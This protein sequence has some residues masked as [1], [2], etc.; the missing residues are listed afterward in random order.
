MSLRRSVRSFARK[1]LTVKNIG[2]P[3]VVLV[4]WGSYGYRGGP[5]LGDLLA[6]DNLSAR[7]AAENIEHAVVSHPEFGFAGHFPVEDIYKIAPARKVVFVCGPL[8]DNRDLRDFLAIHRKARKIAV[9]VSV[10]ENHDRMNRRF[11][12]IVGRD[13]VERSTFDLAI[14][15]ITPPPATFTKKP[16]TIGIC[17]RGKQ[18]EYGKARVAL[19]DKASSI[20]DGLAA[21]S[22]LRPVVI[23]TV[24]TRDNPAEAIAA[25]FHAVDIVL[26]TRMHGALLSL[27][28]GKP[29]IAIDQIPGGAKVSA[30]VGKTGWP[31]VYRAEEVSENMLAGVLKELLM[32]AARDR[33]I[34]A[35][36]AIEKLTE[37]ALTTS[38]GAIALT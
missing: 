21:D 7:L 28:A 13:G 15:E 12:C 11:D 31:F 4:W 35:Q 19:S 18:T 9:G 6:V 22:G 29:V 3:P 16:Q 10:L 8:T 14:S 20:F 2:L 17:V 34:A 32:G 27:A 26:T 5:T 36:S 23:D 25:R 33:I 38:V 1:H 37:H 24:L 30:V